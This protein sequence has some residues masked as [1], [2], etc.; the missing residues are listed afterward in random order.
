[1]GRSSLH[2]A[3]R[4]FNLGRILQIKTLDDHFQI[5]RGFSIERYL[6]TPGT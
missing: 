1:V 3:K 2:R 6:G 5:P 4:T